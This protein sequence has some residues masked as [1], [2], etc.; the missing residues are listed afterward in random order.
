MVI[1]GKAEIWKAAMGTSRVGDDFGDAD[2]ALG[3]V[4]SILQ[5]GSSRETLVRHIIAHPAEHIRSM[6]GGIDA[7]N[8][9]F[10]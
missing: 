4:G 6:G 5:N 1:L 10:R 2:L 8:I 7:G 3:L 9:E